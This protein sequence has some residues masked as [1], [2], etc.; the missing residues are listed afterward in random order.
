[1]RLSGLNM[2][3]R[4]SQGSLNEAH[5]NAAA[6]LA[7]RDKLVRQEHPSEAIGG[8]I[9]PTST[10]SP[11]TS[12]L[13][14]QVKE[15][16]PSGLRSEGIYDYGPVSDLS[17]VSLYGF[18]MHRSQLSQVPENEE[19]TAARRGSIQP[20][21]PLPHIYVQNHLES[22]TPYRTPPSEVR[23][24]SVQPALQQQHYPPGGSFTPQPSFPHP[25]EPSFVP[26]PGSAQSDSPYHQQQPTELQYPPDGAFQGAPNTLTVPHANISRYAPPANEYTY[27]AGHGQEPFASFT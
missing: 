22:Q 10:A 13:I 1:M 3:S 23:A 19:I 20:Q 5:L 15:P 24:S 27:A 16:V 8:Y 2:T 25:G 14:R 6:A 21:D 9:S 11:G 4:S 7:Y 12:P 26:G 17:P 18:L